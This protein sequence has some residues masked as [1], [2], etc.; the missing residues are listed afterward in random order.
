MPKP[1]PITEVWITSCDKHV[2]RPALTEAEAV[3]LSTDRGYHDPTC[4]L[5]VWR[6][7]DSTPER[8]EVIM[9]AAPLLRKAP[10]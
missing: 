3:K 1:A 9:P 4:K 2:P 7:A 6:V 5:E 10:A 8:Y